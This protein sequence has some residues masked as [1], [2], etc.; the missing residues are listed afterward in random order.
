VL[1]ANGQLG[2]DVL[3]AAAAAGVEAV[4]AGRAEADV[5]D[6]AALRAFLDAAEFDV[7]VNCTSYHKTDEVE[8][9]AGLA[10][11]VNAHAPAVMAE[12]CA[13]KGA[14]LPAREHR[15]RLRG[16][17]FARGRRST[18]RRPPPRSTSTG[19]PSSSARRWR[20]SG[21]AT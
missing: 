14:R 8:T 18:R 21:A 1:G 17:P 10:M 9:N 11:A 15:L 7:L 19:C 12:A 3:D 16:R 6:R 13:A 5:T 20:R 4:P 2:G